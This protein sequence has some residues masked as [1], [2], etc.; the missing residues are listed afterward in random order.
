M[1]VLTRQTGWSQGKLTVIYVWAM[2]GEGWRGCLCFS[3]GQSQGLSNFVSYDRLSSRYPAYL[4]CLVRTRR[5]W[6]RLK[7][8]STF[9]ESPATF[10]GNTVCV[11]FDFGVISFCNSQAAD[12]V[13]RALC[14]YGQPL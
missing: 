10:K 12:Q 9:P 4:H 8:R 3:P 1:K 11:H 6:W 2:A 14:P 13:T 7:D 5:Y